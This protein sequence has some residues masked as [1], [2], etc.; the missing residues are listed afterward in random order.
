MLIF[1]RGYTITQNG[2]DYN[3]IVSK[4]GQVVLRKQCHRPLCEVEL[5]EVIDEYIKKRRQ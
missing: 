3:I 4:G 1:Y 5:C 2:Y